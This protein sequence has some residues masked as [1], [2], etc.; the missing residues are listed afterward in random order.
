MSFPCKEEFEKQQMEQIEQMDQAVIIG[1][2][3]MPNEFILP[4]QTQQS[5][6]VQPSG[7]ILNA[8]TT[9]AT[10][11]QPPIMPTQP[12]M[13]IQRFTPFMEQMSNMID[14]RIQ[15]ENQVI[16]VDLENRINEIPAEKL[17]RIKELY[18]EYKSLCE[19]EDYVEICSEIEK[20]QKELT[21]LRKIKKEQEKEAKMLLDL[22]SK[23]MKRYGIEDIQLKNRVIKHEVPVVKVSYSQK[24]LKKALSIMYNDESQAD[25]AMDTIKN[26]IKQ[27]KEKDLE[28]EL[29]IINPDD[30]SKTSRKGKKKK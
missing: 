12:F 4:Q 16:P 11:I 25:N 22:I 19:A 26:I 8:A 14:H 1:Q 18:G 3:G 10:L 2:S 17:M 30:G 23:K 15:T 9:N 6:F 13:P 7:A 28:P 20:K 27:E 5:T 24:N 29:V 21:K